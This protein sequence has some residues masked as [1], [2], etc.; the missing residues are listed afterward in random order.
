MKQKIFA[1]FTGIMLAIA[2]CPVAFIPTLKILPCAIA[3]L[4]IFTVGAISN[5]LNTEETWSSRYETICAYCTIVFFS[6][7]LAFVLPSVYFDF[8]IQLKWNLWQE[9]A[10]IVWVS[11]LVFALALTSWEGRYRISKKWQ[12]A[13]W[14]T[15]A[16]LT[17]VIIYSIISML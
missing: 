9:I 8:D 16:V 14:I 15:V 13:I 17:S 2:A 12:I 1:W 5:G 10:T 4:G 6:A 11:A 7:L 3:F